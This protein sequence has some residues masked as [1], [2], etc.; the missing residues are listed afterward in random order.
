M[1][2][3]YF[4]CVV[5]LMRF[6]NIDDYFNDTT[7]NSCSYYIY[8]Y[9]VTKYAVNSQQINPK[10]NDKTNCH[11]SHINLIELRHHVEITVQ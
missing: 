5:V 6:L 7:V 1:Y 8:V 10:L 11:I 3:H 9:I 2:E 4:K